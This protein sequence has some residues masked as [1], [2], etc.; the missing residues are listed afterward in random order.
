MRESMSKLYEKVSMTTKAVYN[1][2]K[3][4]VLGS[5]GCEQRKIDNVRS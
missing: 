2:V 3:F 5:T 4:S 1:S